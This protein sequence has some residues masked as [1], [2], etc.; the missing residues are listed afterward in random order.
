M[1]V[2]TGKKDQG[3]LDSCPHGIQRQKSHGATEESYDRS[4]DLQVCA[5][6]CTY[7]NG[8][9]PSYTNVRSAR[10]GILTSEM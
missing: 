5:R 7:H 6:G 1:E 8:C 9:K 2:D 10:P 4:V 3:L